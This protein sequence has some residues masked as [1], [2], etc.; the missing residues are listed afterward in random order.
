[1]LLRLR[2][3]EVRR[4]TEMRPGEVHPRCGNDRDEAISKK[5][6]TG[7]KLVVAGPRLL[8]FATPPSFTPLFHDGR[9]LAPLTTGNCS[10]FFLHDR[11]SSRGPIPPLYATTQSQGEV[12]VDTRDL[13]MLPCALPILAIPCGSGEVHYQNGPGRVLL[14]L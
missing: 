4:R 7:I 11:H 2:A 12:L 6:T 10:T 9:R 14:H 8:Q 3:G 1:M 5:C 13:G